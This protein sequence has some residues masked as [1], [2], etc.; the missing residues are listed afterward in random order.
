M[1]SGG[2][3]MGD[4]FHGWASAESVIIIRNMLVREVRLKGDGEALIW[5]SGFREK[6]LSGSASGNNIYTPW[7]VSSLE[8]GKGALTLSGLSTRVM[9]LISLPAGWSALHAETGQ[10]LSP[11]PL[12]QLPA[13][14]TAERTYLVLDAHGDRA[15]LVLSGGEK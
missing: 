2:G 6:W 5:L 9:H 1:R 11:L 12:E 15:S 7:S 4:G 13:P 8:L 3:C 10:R 14:I